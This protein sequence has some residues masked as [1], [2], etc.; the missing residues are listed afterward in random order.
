MVSFCYP[1]LVTDRR[2]EIVPLAE[3]ACEEAGK[4]L[5]PVRWKR[6]FFLNE[7]PLFKKMRVSYRCLP[8][9]EDNAPPPRGE[10]AAVPPATAD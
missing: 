4:G 8:P 9:P 2:E 3:A 10:S 6:S 7:C 1:P 5:E